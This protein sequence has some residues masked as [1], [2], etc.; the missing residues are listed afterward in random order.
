MRSYCQTV[1]PD[2][3]TKETIYVFLAVFTI[4]VCSGIFIHFHQRAIVNLHTLATYE[5]SARYDLKAAEQ[6]IL[7]DLLLVYQDLSLIHI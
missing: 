3:T 7:A 4:I 2:K 6:G 1:H 5:V